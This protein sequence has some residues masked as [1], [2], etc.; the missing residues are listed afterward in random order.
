MGSLL[1]VLV[2]IMHSRAAF[3]SRPNNARLDFPEVLPIGRPNFF[4]LISSLRLI[5]VGR[6]LVGDLQAPAEVF[7]IHLL[8][9]G[10]YVLW[11]HENLL[12]LLILTLH[13]LISLGDYK[14]LFVVQC[15]P[16]RLD[17]AIENLLLRVEVFGD[18]SS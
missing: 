8:L 15:G 16:A 2:V 3:G 12:P 13:K 14:L 9:D 5:V 7:E 4:L 18:T 6:V 10:L 17:P 11:R 1:V